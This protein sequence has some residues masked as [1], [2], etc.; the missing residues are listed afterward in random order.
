LV[1]WRRLLLASR[2]VE[3]GEKVI[4]SLLPFFKGDLSG[5]SF[6][7]WGESAC[8]FTLTSLTIDSPSDFNLWSASYPGDLKISQEGDPAFGSVT[9]LK[10]LQGPRSLSIV[11]QIGDGKFETTQM[12]LQLHDGPGAGALSKDGKVEYLGSTQSGLRVVFQHQVVVSP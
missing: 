11:R 12:E 8:V 2:A 6:G 1:F 7:F 9:S 3:I 5:I 4:M 10:V